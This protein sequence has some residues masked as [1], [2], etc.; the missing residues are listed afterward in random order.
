MPRSKMS[1]ASTVG[2]A[3]PVHV[4]RGQP[5]GKHR[6][7]LRSQFQLNLIQICLREELRLISGREEAAIAVEQGTDLLC[8]S[9]RIPA[10]GGEVADQ[11]EM[12]PERDGR[13]CSSSSARRAPGHGAMTLQELTIP[14]SIEVTTALLTDGYI[15]KSSALM[16]NT[17][18]D[19]YPKSSLESTTIPDQIPNLDSS[20]VPSAPGPSWIW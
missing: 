1:V 16:I 5:S 13:S 11:S 4:G 17:P 2:Q 3:V 8:R 9:H 7:D 20:S 18:S 6:F 10:V 19:G 12:N 14:F 15:P